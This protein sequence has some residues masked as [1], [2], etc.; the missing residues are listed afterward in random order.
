MQ[1]RQYLGAAAALAALSPG[2]ATADSPDGDG[3][4]V[5]VDATY[6]LDKPI[7]AEQGVGHVD[8]DLVLAEVVDW[9]ADLN[10]TAYTGNPAH[11][12]VGVTVSDDDNEIGALAVVDIEQARALRAE[13]DEAITIVEAAAAEHGGEGQ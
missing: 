13:L 10:V 9:T 2:D 1:R 12:H 7:D 8:G 5:Q 3:D 4:S 6:T 11:V